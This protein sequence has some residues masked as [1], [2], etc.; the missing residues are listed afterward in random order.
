MTDPIHDEPSPESPETRARRYDRWVAR[1]GPWLDRLALVFLVSFLLQWL[2]LNPP[3]WVSEALNGIQLL[4]WAAFAI[5]Y[6]TRLTLVDDK[7]DFVR[8][9]KLDLVMVLVPM[10]RMLRVALLLRK[11]LRSISTERI[12]GSLFT[13]V[14]VVVVTAAVLEWNIER[15]TPGANIQT[16]GESLWWAVVTT[17]TV[18]YGDFYPTNAAGRIVGGV[19][20]ILGIGLIGTVSA[21]I[22][23]WFLSR[24]V[25]PTPGAEVEGAGSDSP[26]PAAAAGATGDQ[27]QLILGRL[28]ALAAEQAS[29]R[30]LLESRQTAA[31]GPGPGPGLTARLD[32]PA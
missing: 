14:A 17:T 29:L 16:F 15:Q 8:D 12:A 10:L 1:T 26:E 2:Y 20:M 28:D 3:A 30:A 31:Q 6:V 32:S 9:H 4:V 27:V 23:N 24:K 25:Q 19:L 7:S 18:G 22:A 21:T 5:D 13:M 11:S